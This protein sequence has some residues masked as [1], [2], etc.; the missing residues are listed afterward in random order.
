MG[1]E[2]Y[3]KL[4]VYVPQG[5]E[6]AVRQAICDNGGGWIGNYSDCTFRSQG[7]GTFRARA[8]AIPFLGELDSLTEA[9]EY[10]LETVVPKNKLHKILEAVESVHPYEEV[11]YDL[12]ELQELS[13]NRYIGRVGDLPYEMSMKE[14]LP[15]ISQAIEQVSLN[16]S[17]TEK[18]I[19]RLA[20]C[21]G[22]AASYMDQAKAAGADAYLTADVKF[23][24]YQKAQ[25]LDIVLIDGG[26]F[27]PE[28]WVLEKIRLYLQEKFL[29][30]EI[31]VFDENDFIQ[32]YHY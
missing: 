23:H 29:F 32:H 5:Y 4:V 20:V 22:S 16:Y 27:S 10:R 24:D 30:E 9:T 14:L 3:Y 1:E 25:E 28:K 13:E 19:H 15:Y 17:G 12:F 18:K 6:E 7:I 26:H 2:A 31:S 21:G 11:A 8:G